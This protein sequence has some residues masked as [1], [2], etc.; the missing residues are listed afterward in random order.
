MM[1]NQAKKFTDGFGIELIDI[2]VR[3]I[4]YSDDLTESVYQRMI[5]ER[6]QI[7]EAYRS[8]G[9]GQLAQWQGKT[10]SEQKQILSAAYAT[11]E[12]TKG[13]ADARATQIYADAYAAD[14]QF[15]E[16]WR[17]LESYRKTIPTLEKVLSTDMEYFNLLYGKDQ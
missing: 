6:N 3:Q 5:K 13:I 15:F 16:L 12:Q 4:R 2:V 17:T 9:R 7:A 8:Y 11:A 10:E 14:P 1:Y